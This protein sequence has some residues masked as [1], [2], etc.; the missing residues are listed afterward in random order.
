MQKYWDILY[1]VCVRRHKIIYMFS[2]P[3]D[4]FMSLFSEIVVIGC[5]LREWENDMCLKEEEI[6]V[7]NELLLRWYI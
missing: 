1:N 7:R 3:I 2:L 5:I 4:R 6:G